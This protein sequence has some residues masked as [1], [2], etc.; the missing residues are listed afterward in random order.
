MIL[1]EECWLGEKAEV[2]GS[3][4]PTH[5]RPDY[6]LFVQRAKGPVARSFEKIIS[7]NN[8]FSPNTT[9]TMA[10][11]R[12]HSEVHPSRRELVPGQ[13]KKRKVNPNPH[14]KLERKANPVNPI[15]SRIRSLNRL[16]QHKENLPADVRLNHERELKSCEYDLAIAENQQR[17]KDLI[18][19]YHMVRFFE[20]R[21]AERRLKKLERRA[22]EGEADLDEQIH[23]A[24]V[25]LNYAMYHPLDIVYSALWPTKGKKDAEGNEIEVEKQG[26]PDMWLVV[27][28]CMEEGKLDALRNGKLLKSAPAQLNNDDS[29]GQKASNARAKKEKKDKKVK[30][31]KAA[32]KADEDQVMGGQNEDE[33]SEG[34]FFE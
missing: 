21:K 17:K 19:K 25:D 6:T 24:K 30:D 27:E 13:E 8:P 15:K 33:D 16:L 2:V 26:D 22:K 32:K 11:K 10:T 31:K 14:R 23:E 7:I 4:Y 29:I 18:G 1:Y 3:V 5:C 12:P 34:G 9:S 20:R 28:K